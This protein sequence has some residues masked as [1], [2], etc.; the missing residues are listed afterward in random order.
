MRACV[1]SSACL[2]E[3]P[4][5]AA[6]RLESPAAFAERA[7]ARPEAPTARA[8]ASFRNTVELMILVAACGI[9]VAL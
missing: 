3:A 9:A 5:V 4:P 1:A 2:D 6:P 8:V 7:S